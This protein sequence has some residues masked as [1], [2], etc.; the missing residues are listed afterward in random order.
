MPLA[1]DRGHDEAG[2]RNAA[3]ITMAVFAAGV[4]YFVVLFLLAH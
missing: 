4:I 3:R 1:R 2:T